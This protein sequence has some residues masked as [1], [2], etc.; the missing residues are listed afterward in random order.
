MAVSQL[1][2]VYVILVLVVS[3]FSLLS[4]ALSIC[5]EGFIWST[6][7]VGSKQPARQDIVLTFTIV[8]RN[9]GS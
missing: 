4:M 3:S 5:S 8:G 2:S 6:L 9:G 1:Q 7:A